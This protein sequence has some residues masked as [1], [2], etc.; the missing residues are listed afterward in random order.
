LQSQITL[1]NREGIVTSI[2]GLTGWYLGYTQGKPA[3]P[4]GTSQSWIYWVETGNENPTLA[5]F[6]RIAP[7]LRVELSDLLRAT[8]ARDA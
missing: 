4:A 2:I 8:I 1:S 3:D 7:A 6:S 5:C